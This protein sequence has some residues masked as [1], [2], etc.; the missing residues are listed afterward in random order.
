MRDLWTPRVGFEPPYYAVLHF[1][2]S[3]PTLLSKEGNAVELRSPIQLYGYNYM[4]VNCWTEFSSLFFTKFTNWET[5]LRSGLGE[6]PGPFSLIIASSRN[7]RIPF[8]T[9]DG[10]GFESIPARNQSSLKGWL[11]PSSYGE[12][13]HDLTSLV[14]KYFFWYQS[15]NI[16]WRYKKERNFPSA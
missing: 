12:F 1:E 15:N 14:S 9:D 16:I 7:G 6:V 4:P 11:I 10:R 2:S 5:P 8:H 13:F 3:M